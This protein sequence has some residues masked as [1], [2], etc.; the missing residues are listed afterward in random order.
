[1]RFSLYVYHWSWSHG[2]FTWCH[3]DD[4]LRARLH[5]EGTISSGNWNWQKDFALHTSV[6]NGTFSVWD[7][8]AA[9]DSLFNQLGWKLVCKDKQSTIQ[10]WTTLFSVQWVIMNI[11]VH[12]HL[13]LSW[14]DIVYNLVYCPIGFDMEVSLYLSVQSYKIRSDKVSSLT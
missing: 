11:Q 13:V 4:Q 8:K 10:L 7:F 2:S 3:Y 6:Q 14:N 1:M 9:S 12:S 5:W